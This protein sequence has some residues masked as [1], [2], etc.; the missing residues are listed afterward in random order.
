MTTTAVALPTIPRHAVEVGDVVVSSHYGPVKITSVQRTARSL[1]TDLVGW[2]Y[3]I[4]G[5]RSTVECGERYPGDMPIEVVS[6]AL[7][8]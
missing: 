3:L 6:F 7:E 2:L 8:D 4:N 5:G 1:P